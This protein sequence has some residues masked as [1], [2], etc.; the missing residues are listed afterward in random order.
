MRDMLLACSH[1]A[2]MSSVAISQLKASF[3]H[4][5]WFVA[6]SQGEDELFSTVRTQSTSL[7]LLLALTA[8]AVMLFALWYSTRLAAPPEPEEMDMHLTSHPRVHRIEEPEDVE[9]RV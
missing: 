3:P 6:V 1:V 7:V 9:E 8:M 5:N 2:D 4:T